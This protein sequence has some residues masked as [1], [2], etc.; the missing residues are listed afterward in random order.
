MNELD[1]NLLEYSPEEWYTIQ[2]QHRE[3]ENRQYEAIRGWLKRHAHLFPVVQDVYDDSSYHD[4]I[5]ISNYQVSSISPT[6]VTFCN[7][8]GEDDGDWLDV[9]IDPKELS[10]YLVMLMSNKAKVIEA[11]RKEKEDKEKVK[12]E[13]IALEE[14]CE[15][16]QYLRLKEKF[17]E[18]T[19]RKY[20]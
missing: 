17:K 3:V 5:S 7:I 2:K 4:M 9:P 19:P 10:E 18:Y 15:Y 20:F 8:L 14:D 13:L 6:H 1:T 11:K 16:Q 12:K